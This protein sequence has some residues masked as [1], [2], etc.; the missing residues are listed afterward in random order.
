MVGVWGLGGGLETD[1]F[2]CRHNKENAVWWAD[3]AALGR[4]S[5][6][7]R[8]SSFH[9]MEPING[10]HRTANKEWCFTPEQEPCPCVTDS[11][12]LRRDKPRGLQKSEV[13]C[14]NELVSQ[15]RPIRA[16]ETARDVAILH[17]FTK[18]LFFL[19]GNIDISPDISIH[20]FLEISADR[21]MM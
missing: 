1:V 19:K 11:L 20:R 8:R 5:N 13:M 9:C 2:L 6:I 21:W 3:H 4:T 10:A 16:Q 7:C 17:L 12:S 14:L 15:T 18:T